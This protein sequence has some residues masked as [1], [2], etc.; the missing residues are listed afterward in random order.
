MRIQIPPCYN[1]LKARVASSADELADCRKCADLLRCVQCARWPSESL[2]FWDAMKCSGL[3]GLTGL[4]DMIVKTNNAK[5][6]RITQTVML[7]GV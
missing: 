6:H 5:K 7:I 4:L 3:T 2:V 1:F